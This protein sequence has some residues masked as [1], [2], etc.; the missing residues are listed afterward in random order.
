MPATRK[1]IRGGLVLVENTRFES[2]SLLINTGRIA[3]IIDGDGPPDVPIVDAGGRIVIP[4]LVNGHTHSHG[5]LGRGG[6]PDDATL[7]TFLAG[8][9]ALNGNRHLDDLR[10]SAQL[11]AVATIPAIFTENGT[12]GP[13]LKQTATWTSSSSATASWCVPTSGTTVP[14]SC[15]RRPDLQRRS[16]RHAWRSRP[17]RLCPG[18]PARRL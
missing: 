9:G 14:R 4:G 2:V 7:E 18:H 16:F 8:A 11:S 13:H 6:V 5:A 3:A 15:F 10:L 17:I 1:L 12:T